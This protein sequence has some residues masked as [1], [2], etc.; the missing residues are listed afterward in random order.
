MQF[1]KYLGVKIC[2]SFPS[3]LFLRV[4]HEMFMEVPLFQETSPALKNSWLR[5]WAMSSIYVS[6]II[7]MILLKLLLVE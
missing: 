5:A 1:Q 3:A 7:L 6:I 2:E 4:V